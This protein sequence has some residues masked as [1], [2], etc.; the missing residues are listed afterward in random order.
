[1][2]T[3][4]ATPRGPEPAPE[5]LAPAAPGLR[6]IAA[7]DGT[8][9]PFAALL[10]ALLGAGL[11]VPPDSAPAT[12]ANGEG[13]EVAFVG[14]GGETDGGSL[15]DAAHGPMPG[16]LSAGS[17]EGENPSPPMAINDGPA[18]DGFIPA[19][20]TRPAAPARDPGPQSMAAGTGGEPGPVAIPS[21]GVD[22][23]P[24]ASDPLP[25]PAD[26]RPAVEARPSAPAP[27]SALPA[28][29]AADGNEPLMPVAASAAGSTSATAAP[30]GAADE[31]V[32]AR[33]AAVSD[34][35][36]GGGGDGTP[37]QGE[38]REGTSLPPAEGVDGRAPV[39]ESGDVMPR[40]GVT[41]RTTAPQLPPRAQPAAIP[42]L[43][44]RT[45]A[46]GGRSLRIQLDPP[47]L[48]QLEVAVRTAPGGRLRA[49]IRVQRP[50]ALERLRELEAE[51]GRVLQRSEGSAPVE[52]RFVLADEWQGDEPEG[53]D[54]SPVAPARRPAARGFDVLLAGLVDVRI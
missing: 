32:G 23:P 29:A 46:E 52:L 5:G 36:G 9:S 8:E 39:A 26:P 33:V 10:A 34:A 12:T 48:G 53:R 20:S 25:A 43:L 3:L 41:A 49:T 51:L 19:P 27:V 1:M 35:G 24:E 40:D 30:A 28:A 4:P 54:P 16:A 38:R 47:A 15:P 42:L 18:S 7:E 17:H 31:A 50:E 44:A 45:L 6:S 21:V 2:D 13:S 11:A 14:P 37:L 22:M